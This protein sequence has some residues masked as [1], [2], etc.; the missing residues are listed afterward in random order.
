MK[1]KAFAKL[2]L[3]LNVGP[4][5]NG[6]HSLDGISTTVNLFDQIELEKRS[7]SQVVVIDNVYGEENVAL[8]VARAFVE[9]FSTCGVNIKIKKGIFEKA[10]M[11]GSSADAS[12]VLVGM[13]QLF[14]KD[15]ADVLDVATKFGSDVAYLMCGGLAKISGKGD[16][17]TPLEF[18]PLHFVVVAFF[19]GLS[20]KEVY[21]T[22]DKVG[23][24]VFC[25][26]DKLESCLTSGQ[27]NIAQKLVCNGLSKSAWTVAS[28]KLKDQWQKLDEFCATQNLPPFTLTGSGSAKFVF[29]KDQNEAKDIAEKLLNA[30]FCAV[31]LSSTPCGVA[32]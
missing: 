30:G 12:A 24:D 21:Q 31:A 28:Q 19:E 23:S 1:L 8:K 14:Q 25:D 6:F 3:S 29:A 26:N 20:T 15:K 2:N 17:V 5:E 13:C 9:K 11:G 18:C 22:F 27:I 4:L 32:T 10:G 7:D 16:D